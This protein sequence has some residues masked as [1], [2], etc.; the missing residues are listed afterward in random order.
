MSEI[1]DG[2]GGRG[3]ALNDGTRGMWTSH[4]GLA[5]DSGGRTEGR[6]G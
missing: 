2:Q 6:G 4:D 3:G 1:Q 5:A